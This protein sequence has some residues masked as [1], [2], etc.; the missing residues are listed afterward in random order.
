MANS[1]KEIE[2][3]NFELLDT[4]SS[5]LGNISKFFSE[6]FRSVTG[7]LGCAV[8]VFFIF[9]GI[10]A[11]FITKYN[12]NEVMLGDRLFPPLFFGGSTDHILGTDA[13]GRDLFSR[14]V[15]G[16]RVSL[17]VAFAVVLIASVVGVSAGLLAGFYGRWVDQ[18]IMRIVDTQ[19]AFPG[20]LL[21]IVIL[22]ALGPSVS[23]VIIVLS[24]NGWM[25]HAR[26]VRGLVL[27]LK[28]NEFVEAAELAG[29]RPIRIM[30]RHMLPNLTSTLLTLV[31]LEFARI[32]LAEAALSFLGY[33]VQAPEASWGLIL[34]EGQNY[35]SSGWW[36]VI[37]PGMVISITVMSA[38]LF[39]S[40]LR[41]YADPK[42]REKQYGRDF[43]RK[44]KVKND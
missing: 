20:I 41:V 4:S 11:P 38:N 35:L 31:V 18:L 29:A 23:L 39:A 26:M 44:A 14:V 32:I 9:L 28:T 17:F 7:L 34:A 12:P 8:V 13:L 25:V 43:D 10:M 27:S 22:Y 5:K 19:L 40:W 21:A 6:L 30:F 42:L 3:S 36:L 37:I 2:L 1:L 15:F 24:M 16:A 33:G